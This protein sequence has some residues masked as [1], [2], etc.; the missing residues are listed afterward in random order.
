MTVAESLKRFRKNFNLKQKDVAA[1]LGVTPQAYQVYESR[2]KPSVTVIINLANHFKVSADYLL[3]LTDEPHPT[4]KDNQV[5]DEDIKSLES[6]AQ[7]T[8]NLDFYEALKNVLAK[9]GTEI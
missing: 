2:V 1:V 9:Q 8:G 4:Y 5:E 6:V 7:S 3:G